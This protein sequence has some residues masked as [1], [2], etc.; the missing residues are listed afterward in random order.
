MTSASIVIRDQEAR[1]DAAHQLIAEANRTTAALCAALNHAHEALFWHDGLR[2][3]I[4]GKT[5]EQAITDALARIE[6]GAP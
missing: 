3:E 2:F 6:G 1:L 5:A 4:G